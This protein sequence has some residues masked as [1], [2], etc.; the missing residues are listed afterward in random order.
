MN[1]SGFL[2][3][4]DELTIELATYYIHFVYPKY[5]NPK[6]DIN[7]FLISQIA[8]KMF[9]Q[10]EKV[11]DKTKLAALYHHLNLSIKTINEI[12]EAERSGNIVAWDKTQKRSHPKVFWKHELSKRI[13]SK[14]DT[15]KKVYGNLVISYETAISVVYSI[16]FGLM[17]EEDAGDY[18]L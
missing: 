13:S 11:K 18:I 5:M 2:N 12:I 16:K 8:T 6:Q 14:K 7:S 9:V 10:L 1:S 17:R 3:Q 4:E 15:L